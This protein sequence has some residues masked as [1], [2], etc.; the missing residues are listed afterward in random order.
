M[1]QAGAEEGVE[2]LVRRGAREGERV[3]VDVLRLGRERLE[4]VLGHQ[5]LARAVRPVQ[6]HVLARHV[7]VL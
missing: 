4:E 3:Q 6:Q 7:Q 1:V 5:R 2:L